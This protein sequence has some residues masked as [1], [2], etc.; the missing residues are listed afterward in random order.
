MAAINFTVKEDEVC[1]KMYC[2]ENISEVIYNREILWQ[3]KN[4]KMYKDLYEKYVDH[5]GNDCDY[6]TNPFNFKWT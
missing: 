6:H 1:S 5:D 4:S 2:K 3:F